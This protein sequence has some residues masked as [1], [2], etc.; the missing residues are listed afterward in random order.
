MVC[1]T[2]LLTITIEEHSGCYRHSRH[3]RRSPV[4]AVLILGAFI[5]TQNSLGHVCCQ[6]FRDSASC[7]RDIVKRSESI[8]VLCARAV[9]RSEALS[10]NED[11]WDVA[12]YFSQS[13]CC[14]G[15]QSEVAKQRDKW[16]G[17][18][19]AWVSV[20]FLGQF[21]QPINNFINQRINKS[22]SNLITLPSGEGV[23]GKKA[24]S[25]Q[26]EG[27]PASPQWLQRVPSTSLT[28]K[29]EKNKKYTTNKRNNTGVNQYSITK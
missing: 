11:R 19:R 22:I 23:R 25:K 17:S 1:V 13:R 5:G 29:R 27:L 2:H 26:L 12:D 16:A 3:P 9:P 20:C 28:A 6:Y 4:L 14:E 21:N 18:E 7:F 8:A 24:V 10:A 15:E